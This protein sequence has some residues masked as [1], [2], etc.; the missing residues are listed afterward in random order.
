M[1]KERSPEVFMALKDTVC[2]MRKEL[3]DLCRDLE[4]ANAGNKAAS[5]RVRTATIKLTKISK[6]YRKESILAERKELKKLIKPV[7]PK[8]KR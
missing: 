3:A 6:I 4:K 8:K 1:E 2:L 7:S 5:Q